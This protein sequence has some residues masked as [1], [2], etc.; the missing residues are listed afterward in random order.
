MFHKTARVASLGTFSLDGEGLVRI[1]RAEVEGGGDEPRGSF[2]IDGARKLDVRGLLKRVASQY[3]ISDDPSSYFFEAIRA[4]TTNC[5]NE[6]ND[7]FHQSELL[8]FDVRLGMPVFV[9]Y[10]GKPHH[11]NHKTDNPKAAR[12]V[13]IDSHYNSDAPALDTCL[14]CQT[15]TAERQNRDETGLHCRKCGTLVRDEFVEIL[16][17]I[18][19]RKDPLFAEG[20]RKGTLK[21]GSMGCNCLSTTC[22]V[23]GHVAYAKPEFCEHI[24]A[25]NKGTLWTRRG[26]G[27]AKTSAS[28]VSKELRRRKLAFVPADF[29]YVKT[30]DFE[31]RKAF[32]YCNQVIFDEYSRVDMPA[33]PKALQV[34]ILKAAQL[35]GAPAAD[36][37][38]A[39]TEALMRSAERKRKELEASMSRAAQRIPRVPTVSP[40]LTPMEQE[41]VGI[42][43]EQGDDPI[44]IEPPG[45]PGMQEPGM[46]GAPGAPDAPG[47]G[48][49]NIEQYTQQE[50]PGAPGGQPP[51]GEE[52]DMGELGVLPVPPGASAPR[53]GGRRAMRKFSQ[54]YSK[55]TVQV[56][57]QGNARLLTEDR[58]PALVFR[59]AK[60]VQDPE[61]RRAFG[62]EVLT[63]LLDNGLVATAK[64]YGAYF[65]PKFAQVVEHATDD[66]REFADKYLYSSVL[67]GAPSQ[68]DMDGSLRGTPPATTRVDPRDDMDGDVRGKPPVDTQSDGAADHDRKDQNV[69]SAV[70]E[71]HETMREK[72]KPFNMGKDTALNNEVHD[73]VEPLSGKKGE[74]AGRKPN[75]PSAPEAL[76]LGARIAAKAGGD[77]F[78]VVGMRLGEKGLEVELIGA[79]KKASRRVTAGD[80]ADWIRI[81]KQPATLRLPGQATQVFA[82]AEKCAKCGA[83]MFGGADKHTCADGDKDDKKVAAAVRL[84]KVAAA[85][86]AKAKEELA[87]AK[88]EAAEQAKVTAEATVKSFCRALRIVAARQGADLEQSPLKLA[89]EAVL[90]EPRPVGKDAA[91]G[92]TIVYNGLDPELTRFMVAQLY[93]IG[94][95]DH[96][97]RLMHRAA[98]LMSK[99]DQYLIDAEADLKNLNRDLPVISRTRVAAVDEDALHAAELRRQ[100]MGGNLQL[101]PAPSE[102]AVGNGHDKRAAIR[103]ALG[104][105]LVEGARGRLGLGV[106]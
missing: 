39:E 24:R 48:P 13:I 98:E 57:E 49:T 3:A 58:T 65:A 25:G 55:W 97:E 100:A 38:R 23:C 53:R 106:N 62:L 96:L 67:E 70:G 104:G 43:L 89:A 85:K 84:E 73:H 64:K 59:A 22:N 90:S 10:A 88:L 40:M 16:V 91:S 95:A 103:G 15:R 83:L 11:L 37:L 30:G 17:G 66:M 60:P 50:T 79:D 18:D 92:E 105:T 69:D 33:D 76:Q 47:M 35:E 1:A 78:E 94:H 42:Q 86:L 29:C 7:G 77:S 34:E 101:T 74:A 68:D 54:A 19:A 28:D 6:N 12:G 93:E 26:N 51:P 81:D 5:P 45:T 102:A 80:I 9:T 61:A 52:M 21:A 36:A 46:P 20:V 82:A 87:K 99:G 27:W 56:S 4:N 75:P 41:G 31:A 2:F 32:E 63:H 71:D 8:R 14:G 44:V 72:R